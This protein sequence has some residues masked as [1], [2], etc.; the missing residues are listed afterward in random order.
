MSGYPHLQMFNYLQSLWN[1]L[2]YF[3]VEK[4]GGKFVANDR[5]MKLKMSNIQNKR[6]HRQKVTKYSQ[7]I[8]TT[9]QA[10]QIYV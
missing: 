3:G 8:I 1:R 7:L 6:H 2:G 9:R 10:E 4:N 5:F